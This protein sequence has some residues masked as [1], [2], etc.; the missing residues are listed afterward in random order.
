MSDAAVLVLGPEASTKTN[1]TLLLSWEKPQ[2]LGGA[3]WLGSARPKTWV[4]DQRTS[5]GMFKFW[6]TRMITATPTT[7]RTTATW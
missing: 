6:Y 3:D 7:A 2:F 5:T 4:R 1:S